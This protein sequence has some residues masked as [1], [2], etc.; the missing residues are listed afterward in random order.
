VVSGDRRLG[1]WRYAAPVSKPSVVLV[2]EKYDVGE[3]EERK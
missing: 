3:N 1:T 2:R